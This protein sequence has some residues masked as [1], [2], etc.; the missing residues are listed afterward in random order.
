MNTKTTKKAVPQ[1][2]PKTATV[3]LDEMGATKLEL[4]HSRAESAANALAARR[5][6]LENVLAQVR[7]HYEENGKYVVLKIDATKR[8]VERVLASDVKAATPFRHAPEPASAP[9]NGVD[10]PTG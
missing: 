1:Q 8:E 9:P 10:H 7:T 6:E 3:P 4:A 5:A 2:A